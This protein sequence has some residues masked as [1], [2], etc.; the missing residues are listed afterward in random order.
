MKI[1]PWTLARLNAE[2][3]S[4]AAAEARKKSKILQPV[5][6]KEGG[7]MG[8]NRLER[9]KSFGRSDRHM[10]SSRLGNKQQ[11]HI[12][13]S[14]NSRKFGNDDRVMD[15][16]LSS[17]VPLQLEAQGV[18]TAI[19]SSPDSSLDSPNIQ[20]CMVTSGAGRTGMPKDARVSGGPE[21]Q[22]TA[23]FNRSMSDG[24]DASGGEDSDRVLSRT[25]QRSGNSSARLFDVDQ[26]DK[27]ARLK[28]PSSSKSSYPTGSKI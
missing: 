6:R 2:D 20:P 11:P 27:I 26:D 28:M 8:S 21:K 19:S 10:S 13:E 25:V 12:T 18:F 9:D 5:S 4:K 22:G 14:K 3:V 17:L 7:Q 16:I 1:S 24:Y 23:S 15:G